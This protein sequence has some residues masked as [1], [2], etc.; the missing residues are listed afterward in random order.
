MSNNKQKRRDFLSTFSI[1][2]M[3]ALG[4]PVFTF[5]NTFTQQKND[6]LSPWQEGFLDIHHINTGAGDS[7]L[8]VFPDGTTMLLDAGALVRERPENY[9]SPQIPDNSRRPGQWIARYIQAFHPK[10]EK[11]ILDYGVITHFHADHIGSVNDTS[12][13][14]ES[15]AYRLTGISDVGTD[16]QIQ[17]MIDRAWPDYN[18]PKPL[19]NNKDIEN[20]RNFIR[21]Q[22]LKNE[23]EVQQFVPGRKDQIKPIHAPAKYQDF[24]LQNLAVNGKIWTG[25]STEIRNRF[26]ENEFPNE[27]SSSIAF[28]INYGNFT[29]YTGGDL[30]GAISPNAPEWRDVESALA[31][32]VGPVD[33]HVSDHHGLN[34]NSFFLSVLQPRVHIISD[35]ASSQ[36]SPDVMQRMLSEKIYPGPRDIFLLNGLWEG[37]KANMINL[38]GQEKTSFLE[39]NI[40]KAASSQGHI[41]VRVYSGGVN[42]HIFVL[43]EKNLSVISKHGMYTTVKK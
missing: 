25:F 11:G 42:Y 31:W 17:K 1:G 4:M 41:V 39:S 43:E 33:I 12:P 9:D 15:G 40:K 34:T 10:G 19:D 29:Y 2:T 32:L 24:T 27:N 18:C 22:I 35:Y 37:R 21:Y 26:P 7:T 3:G 38:Y 8:F 23:M 16:I 14:S 5:S 28:R 30:E 13:V 36:P 20:Y 6:R